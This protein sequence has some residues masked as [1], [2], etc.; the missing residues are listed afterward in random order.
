MRSYDRKNPQLFSV[1]SEPDIAIMQSA[2]NKA[3]EVNIDLDFVQKNLLPK[4]LKVKFKNSEYNKLTFVENLSQ[5]YSAIRVIQFQ[6]ESNNPVTLYLK[7]IT[8]PNKKI[9]TVKESLLNETSLLQK[10][11]TA[12]KGAT[13]EHIA[14]FPE[15]QIIVT[16]KCPG[17]P[18]DSIINTYGFWWRN[19]ISKK[20]YRDNIPALCGNWLKRFHIATG[21]ENQDLTPWYNYLSG[22]MIWRTRILKERL[23]KHSE[24]FENISDS[25]TNELRKIKTQGYL[26]TYHGDFA[27]H[28][29]FYDEGKIRVIDFYGARVGHPLIDI[30][31]FIA[32]I[33]CRAE[34]PLYPK[35]RVKK[36]CQQFFTA[37]GQGFDK[38]T[39]LAPLILL[40][41]S[42]KRVLV[43]S[44]DTPTRL[45]RKLITQHA[46]HQHISYLKDYLQENNNAHKNGPWAFLDLPMLKY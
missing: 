2:K 28:N 22:E 15:Q 42:M 9:A 7:R 30:I 8:I 6:D 5:P 29:I 16:K 45:D 20:I 44:S 32:S 34:S 43:L 35:S 12:M 4:V 33:V 36:F 38:S 11:N 31:N 1:T 46:M 17:L 13:A 19:N 24:L 18:V 3:S 41:Q 40:L 23:P 25:F 39:A 26:C 14:V 27:P 10:I 21:E 37:Y